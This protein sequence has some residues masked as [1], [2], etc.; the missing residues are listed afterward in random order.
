MRE[1]KKNT[2]T[3]TINDGRD[4]SIEHIAIHLW[5]G[6]NSDL[7]PELEGREGDALPHSQRKSNH[8]GFRPP[9]L[10]LMQTTPRGQPLH[11]PLMCRSRRE[12]ASPPTRA[13]HAE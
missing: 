9:H 13:D 1:T 5:T 2:T 3:R 12:T 11:L 10:P 7:D 6:P 4:N 8:K